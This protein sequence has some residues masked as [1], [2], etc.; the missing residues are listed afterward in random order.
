[1]ARTIFATFDSVFMASRAVQ[2][3]RESGLSQDR[4]DILSRSATA[5]PDPADWL[6]SAEGKAAPIE[7]E[8]RVTGAQAGI[9]IGLGVGIAVGITSGLLA[10][11]GD[12]PLP[13]ML[14]L[15]PLSHT[16]AA[17]TVAMASVLAGGAAGGALGDLISLGIPEEEMRQ[18]ARTV[19]DDKI[20]VAILADWD[21][22][23]PMIQIL[24][25][26]NPL[27][28]E[29]KPYSRLKSG[30]LKKSSPAL[31]IQAPQRERENRR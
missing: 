19:R 23:D 30:W 20:V 21:T 8:V 7:P 4:V 31:G 3:L 28:I 14:D 22:V 17:L 27:S 9:L 16:A 29:E 6:N 18:Y 26:H 11:L 13:G 2:D 1:M 25:R 15:G 24:S 10:W 12:I 5:G